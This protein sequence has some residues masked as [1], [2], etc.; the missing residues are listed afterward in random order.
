MHLPE[1][2]FLFP[3]SLFMNFRGAFRCLTFTGNRQSFLTSSVCP[4]SLLPEC[5]FFLSIAQTSF[6]RFAAL[7]SKF[8]LDFQRIS[9]CKPR[10]RRCRTLCQAICRPFAIYWV[11]NPFSCCM[12]TWTLKFIMWASSMKLQ[13]WPLISSFFYFSQIYNLLYKWSNK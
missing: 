1:A 4:V 13:T 8:I 6:L 10:W 11:S 3:W 12:Y 9:A 2:M 5:F 7:T